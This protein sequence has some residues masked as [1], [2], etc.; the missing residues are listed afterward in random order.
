M[1]LPTALG[2]R[3]ALQLQMSFG[4]R[5]MKTTTKGEGYALVNTGPLC[6]TNTAR[7]IERAGIGR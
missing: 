5:A 1:H 6:S 7:P 4:L 2:E 3:V